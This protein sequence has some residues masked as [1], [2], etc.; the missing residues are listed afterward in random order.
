MTFADG[1]RIDKGIGT[2]IAIVGMAEIEAVTEN[3]VETEIETA[4][5][6][7]TTGTATVVIEEIVTAIGTSR[8]RR[9][10]KSP[11]HL[12]PRQERR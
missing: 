12:S 3:M 1:R 8:Q 10:R 5:I 9:R 7:E 11:R 2:V 6:A 4:I